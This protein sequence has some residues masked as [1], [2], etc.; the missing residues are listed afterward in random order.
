MQ[1]YIDDEFVLAGFS[2]RFNGVSSGAYDSLN[3]AFNVGDDP[4]NVYENREIFKAKISAKKVVFMDQI[5]S[6]IIENVLNLGDILK[7][8]DALTTSLQ[9]ICLCVLVADC[10]PV[11][12]YD[13]TKQ[14]IAT[15]HAG[16]AGVI[17]KII[18]KTVLKM[19]S[20]PDDLR[21]IVGAN[22][23][24][25][26]YEIGSLDLREFN[27]FKING[28]FDIN[29][30][31]KTEFKELGIKRYIFNESC[32]HCDEA[33]FS[34]RRDKICGRFCGFIMLKNKNVR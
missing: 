2:D 13:K 8:C 4:Q 34:Y 27:K 20:N 19:Q 33:Y 16:R 7:P 10:A 32:T 1:V 6:D 11:L 14:K 15:I 30:A 28:K 3:L 29:M 24:V 17:N 22:I 9:N 12:L 23:K 31:I 26:C 21:A 5:H 18:T 25:D